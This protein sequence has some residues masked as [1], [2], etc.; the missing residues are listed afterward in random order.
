[1]INN[2][3]HLDRVLRFAL[4]LVLLAWALGAFGASPAM[5][6]GRIGLIPALTAVFGWCPFYA[7]LGIDTAHG[8]HA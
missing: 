5:A 7:I 2:I 4:G 6:L 8:H 1:M 3:G